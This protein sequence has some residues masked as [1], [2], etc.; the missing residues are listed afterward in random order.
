MRP[1]S[2]RSWSRRSSVA[3][4]VV[5]T[6][7]LF[8]GCGSRL[9]DEAIANAAHRPIIHGSALPGS[10]SSSTQAD[11]STG[12]SSSPTGSTG[13]GATTGATATGGATPG[14]PAATASH[15]AG[16]TPAAG[17][18][19]GSGAAAKLSTI[20]LGNVGTYSGV[21]GAVFS[22]AEQTVQVWQAYT[23]AHGGLNGH[24]IHVYI[25]DD[26][27][28]PSTSATDIQQE[29]SQDH[30]IAFVGNLVPLTASAGVSYLQQQNIPVI[31]G[32]A[33]STVW[34][35]SPM[36]FPASGSDVGAYQANFT[37]KQA[38]AKGDTKMGVLYCVEDP[39]C[40]QGYTALV[41]QQSA[42]QYGIQAV[43]SSSFSITQPDFTAQ[44]LDAKQ[45]GANFIYF[46][47]DGDSL[48]RMANDCTAQGYNP[49]YLG[50]SIAITANLATNSHLNGLIAGQ[51]NFPWVDN[52]TPAQQV[53]QQAMKQYAP[54]LQG[55]A[56]TA[57]EWAAGELAV[58]ASKDLT[59]NPTSAQF[60]QG[61][62]SI[63]GDNLG[64][65]SPPLTFNT[66]APATP[67]NC[68]F[69]MVLQ[70]GQFTDPQ[71]GASACV[72]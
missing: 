23:N 47:G 62:W 46:A 20:N 55:S 58:A 65:L 66:N 13:S 54:N 11:A 19:A 15:T 45:A 51:T 59:A 12:S 22:G 4:A 60:L 68:Y 2:P 64:G 41:Q 50:D 43:Y 5:C 34:W 21:I 32:D 40:T 9:S 16:T 36:L 10:S 37:V 25:E 7:A 63:K 72:S 3:L 52:F 39:T 71:S 35:Q 26:G 18:S 61:L 57:A 14:S 44:C 42:A 70:N 27:G 17:S 1:S 31:G 28:D 48:M 53:Y 38:A 33:S 30:V 67:S 29:V 69:L 6:A 49:L 56:S 8:A 24:P